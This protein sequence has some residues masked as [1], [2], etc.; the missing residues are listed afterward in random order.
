MLFQRRRQFRLFNDASLE[1]CPNLVSPSQRNP[2][3]FQPIKSLADAPTIHAT[4]PSVRE[5]DPGVTAPEISLHVMRAIEGGF[6]EVHDGVD[7]IDY[8][9]DAPGAYRIE[10]RIVPH[11]LAGWL[12]DYV[13]LADA[14]RPWIYANAFF[15]RP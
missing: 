15:V 14:P 11:H 2:L 4:A 6:E 12:G 3:R 9:P 7:T 5:L 13:A 10:V 1:T 8:V